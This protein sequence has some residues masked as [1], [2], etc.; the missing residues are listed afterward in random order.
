MTSHFGFPLETL[1]IFVCVVAVSI[2]MDLFA[3]RNSTEIRLRD[4]VGWSV[5]WVSLALSFYGYLWV[6]FDKSWADLYLAGY[7]LEKALSVDNLM[8]F[9]AIFAS[10]GVRGADQHRV[11]YWGILGAIVFR[12][13]FV[14]IGAGLFLWAPWVGFVFAAIVLW[15]AWKM[16]TAGSQHQE[17]EDYSDHWS[18]RI[19][20]RFVPVL[21]QRDGH[22]F[23]VGARRAASLAAATG[24]AVVGSGRKALFYVT[25]MFLCL[26]AIEAS[27]I[28]FAFDSVPAIIAVTHEP[29]LVYAAMIFA[30]LG[31]RSL[32]FVLAAATRYVV[33]LDKAVIALLFF[34]AFKLVFHAIEQISGWHPFEIT[35]TMSLLVILG[36][37]GAGCV[38]SFLW[39]GPKDGGQEQS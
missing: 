4:A 1:G 7:A 27:D 34:I 11:L 36:V 16:L 23:F 38:A 14:G 33:H 19:A 35:P 29:L 24:A 39:P 13:I 22:A 6:R 3:H 9:M 18:V 26:I 30:M 12:A 32:Y 28:M 31:L 21:P 20:R 8:V 37:L 10:F 15:T 5:F 17:I 2:F 25:P